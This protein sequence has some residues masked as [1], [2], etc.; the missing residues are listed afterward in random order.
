MANKGVVSWNTEM[1]HQ[2]SISEK[3]PS[4][5]TR[6]SLQVPA[7]QHLHIFHQHSAAVLG[8]CQ[9]ISACQGQ[10]L[11]LSLS[12]TCK[13]H[14]TGWP[15]AFSAQFQSFSSIRAREIV[16]AQITHFLPKFFTSF[17]LPSLKGRA[18]HLCH[19]LKASMC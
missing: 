15:S 19:C 1:A 3:S 11:H 14:T 16:T 7:S 12:V 18:S 9:I 10:S 8:I 6:W 5:Q 17:L 4:E 13:D 2:M